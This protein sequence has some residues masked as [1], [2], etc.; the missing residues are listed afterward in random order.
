M[1][2]VRLGCEID[3]WPSVEQRQSLTVFVFGDFS[4]MIRFCWAY[5]Q[6]NAKQIVD[7][8]NSVGS[9]T[10]QRLCAMHRRETGKSLNLGRH[11]VNCVRRITIIV[12]IVSPRPV[13]C[14]RL[15]GIPFFLFELT[16]AGTPFNEF[17]VIWALNLTANRRKKIVC[18]SEEQQQ[19]HETKL[20]HIIVISVILGVLKIAL[21]RIKHVAVEW[22]PLEFLVTA[23][24]LWWTIWWMLHLFR[25]AEETLHLRVSRC[26]ESLRVNF[27]YNCDRLML[28][29]GEGPNATQAFLRTWNTF[30]FRE[31]DWTKAK[32]INDVVMI[33]YDV[34]S[35]SGFALV[36]CWKSKPARVRLNRV[37][38]LFSWT[39][40]Q[41]LGAKWFN[42]RFSS[43]TELIW[44][45]SGLQTASDSSRHDAT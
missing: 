15:E 7:T 40:A 25:N 31:C 13:D 16:L 36:P 22:W 14:M 17:H 42:S 45:Y 5:T 20:K 24:R 37:A 19:K 8:M 35:K 41:S 30:G 34:I 27:D 4:R 32:I 3:Y 11:T 33:F 1:Q 23:I 44:N 10:C 12:G 29:F 9:K 21:R 28:A 39:F 38:V 6:T 18:I 43:R 2:N 26:S